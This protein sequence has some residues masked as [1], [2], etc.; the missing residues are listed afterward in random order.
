M[1]LQQLGQQYKYSNISGR[2]V[3]NIQLEPFLVSLSPSFI[4]DVIGK[5]VESKPIYSVAFGTGKKKILMWSQMHGNESTTTKGL[6]D[7]LHFLNTNTVLSST[8]LD[9]F[10]VLCIPILNPDGAERYTRINANLVDLNRDAKDITQPES[11]IL[12]QVYL[13]FK[14]D[15]CFNLHDQRTIFGTEGKDLPATMSF[16]APAYN[17]D[18]EYNDSRLKAVQVIN[19]INDNL[20]DL[21]PNQV[22]RFDDSFNDNCIGDYLMTQNTPTLLF[23]AGHYQNDYQRDVVREFVFVSLYSAM[24]GVHES[25]E[26]DIVNNVLDKYLNIPQNKKYFFDFLYK[27]VNIFKDDIEK[28]ITFAAQYEEV[29]EGGEIKFIAKIEAVEL[30]SEFKGHVEYDA[31]NKKFNSEFG[32]YPLISKKA[33]FSL[34]KMLNF[35]NGLQL[36]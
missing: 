19:K 34:N 36:F 14:P 7:F 20:Q 32:D 1:N 11:K 12:R 6:I 21:I 26:N 10:S 5:S 31:E 3:T 22:G 2:Y 35:Y 4:I 29:L 25:Y 8:F 18:R 15:F 13:E 16:L 9:E 23:E 17:E 28:R 33:D 30:S 27:N 24:L